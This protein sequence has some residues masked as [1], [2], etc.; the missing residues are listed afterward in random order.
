MIPPLSKYQKATLKQSSPQL[1]QEVAEQS[2]QG[3]EDQIAEIAYYKA[4]SRDFYVRP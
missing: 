3:I 1:Y 4:E 2:G